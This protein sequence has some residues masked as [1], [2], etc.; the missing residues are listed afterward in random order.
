VKSTDPQPFAVR[1]EN[2]SK[3]Y[4]L[5]ATPK[6]RLLSQMGLGFT[7][8]KSKRAYSLFHALHD[9]NFSIAR[10]ER[11]GLVGR[12]GAGKTTLLKLITDN[13]EPTSGRVLVNGSV[14][15]LMQLGLGFHPEF[16]GLENIRS[17]LSYN[18]LVGAELEEAVEDVIDFVE[19]GEFLNQPLKTY[20]LGMNARLQFAAA[21]A[22]R[23]DILLVDEV[24]SAGDSYFSAKSAFRM[25][26]LAKSGCTLIL[27]SHSWQQIQQYCRRCIWLLDGRVHMDGPTHEVMA[28]YEVMIAE[29]TARKRKQMLGSAQNGETATSASNL[30][31]EA[32]TP[33]TEKAA[34]ASGQHSVESVV[35][36]SSGEK[37]SADFSNAE[38]PHG[39]DLAR[40]TLSTADNCGVAAEV[41][42]HETFEEDDNYI[43]PQPESPASEEAPLVAAGVDYAEVDWLVERLREHDGSTAD[44]EKRDTLRDGQRVFRI[45]GIP[46]LYF[47]YV[48]LTQAGQRVVVA[49]TGKPLKVQLELKSD[50]DGDFECTYWIHF[51]GLDGR[52]ICRIE[53]APDAFH[54]DRGDVRKVSIDMSPLLLGGG[55]YLISFSVF[56]LSKTGNA[57]DTLGTRFEMLARSYQLKVKVPTD[58]DPPNFHYPARWTFGSGPKS[59]PSLIRG[60]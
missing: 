57:A 25:D 10:G 15:A 1:F 50:F 4:R 14:Q 7:L 47:N 48:A 6:S 33:K 55:D 3:S 24:L 36:R 34:I 29:E 60:A 49:E 42:E 38:M 30:T 8:P 11:I 22:I 32:R 12:N 40:R 45:K 59:V 58:S 31:S 46:G 2:V 41:S 19:L 20:S 17:A 52:R 39:S 43:T 54:L 13:F 18:G 53:S 27:V 9:I 37:V 44:T 21:T 35:T 16:S 26:K 28:K 56:D 23:P 5:Y 51:F